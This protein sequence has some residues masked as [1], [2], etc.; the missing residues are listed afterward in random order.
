MYMYICVIILVIVIIGTLTTLPQ[1]LSLII[2][3]DERIPTGLATDVI[4]TAVYNTTKQVDSQLFSENPS[5]AVISNNQIVGVAAGTSVI[6][7]TYR[8][9]IVRKTITVTDASLVAISIIPS[10]P[11]VSIDQQLQLTS[12]A[13]YSDG[14][15][16][17]ITRQSTWSSSV[18]SIATVNQQGTIV[19]VSN[20]TTT[21]RSTRQAITG[22]VTV[23]V[24]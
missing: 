15:S 24:G 3:F 20:G 6:T 17:D 4:T 8:G 1:P 10:N 23:T 5:V 18:D 19:G 11:T 13:T 16:Y 9:V 12:Y 21:I 7:S 2:T 22:T 14:S